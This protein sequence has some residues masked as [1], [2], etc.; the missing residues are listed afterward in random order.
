MYSMTISVWLS[1]SDCSVIMCTLCVRAL[2]FTVLK[3]MGQR[4]GGW[5]IWGHSGLF[6]QCVTVNSV[7]HM[8]SYS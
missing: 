6:D 7:I 4:M 1:V 2:M 8:C 5:V 3:G